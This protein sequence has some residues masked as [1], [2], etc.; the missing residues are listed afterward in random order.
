[1]LN[2]IS[3]PTRCGASRLYGRVSVR[4]GLRPAPGRT[5]T[6]NHAEA[7][8]SYRRVSA[9]PPTIATAPMICAALICSPPT[10]QAIST[11]TTGTRLP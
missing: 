3:K 6:L 7:G 5:T 2:K 10:A 4:A 9:S 11:P 8:W 1:M